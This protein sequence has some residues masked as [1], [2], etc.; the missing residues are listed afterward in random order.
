M[1]GNAMLAVW[2]TLPVSLWG[3]H[4]TRF[5]AEGLQAKANKRPVVMLFI[6][7][8]SKIRERQLTLYGSIICKW[9]SN[10]MI[11]EV[12]ANA[13]FTCSLSGKAHE[14]T[15]FGQ[16]PQKKQVLNVTVPD[17]ADL[18][19]HDIMWYMACDKC[20]RS[21]SENGS[22][23]KC[24][25][26]GATQAEARYQLAIHGVNPSDFKNDDA[27]TVDFVVFGPVAEEL[28][29]IPALTLVALV[30]GHRDLVPI[31]IARLYDRQLTIKVN[32]SHR[33]L[34]MRRVS[35]QVDSMSI[36]ALKITDKFTTSDD[37]QLPMLADKAAETEPSSTLNQTAQSGGPLHEHTVENIMIDIPT[38]TNT[39]ATIT[40]PTTGVTQVVPQ[41]IYE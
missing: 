31:K 27:T 35:Y 32:A 14:I 13:C 30:Q 24:I 26:C 8:T 38:P 16:A 1:E 10:P 15:W 5:D 23:Y 37:T 21:A 2:E 34:Q 22:S 39:N 6:G 33:S 28:I 4:A 11:P 7:L 40:H 3:P 20:K 41:N 29:G 18:N 17:I 25:R 12:V 36:I 19:P 9:Y